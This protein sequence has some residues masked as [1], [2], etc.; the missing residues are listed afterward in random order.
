MRKS[1]RVLNIVN[2]I[3]NWLNHYMPV[4]HSWL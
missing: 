4:I 2:R 3:V 1:N